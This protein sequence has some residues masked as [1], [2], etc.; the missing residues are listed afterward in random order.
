MN[1]LPYLE[2]LSG[3]AVYMRAYGTIIGKN[4]NGRLTDFAMKVGMLSA[5]QKF[6]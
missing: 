2:V 6:K 5:N 4:K 1:R 3:S